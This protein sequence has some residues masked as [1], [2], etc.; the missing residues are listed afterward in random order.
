[1][2]VILAIQEAEIKRI[3]VQRQPQANS[4]ER[5]YLEKTLHTKGLVVWL[6]V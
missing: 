1:M 2:P 3:E 4:S 5:P 6:K